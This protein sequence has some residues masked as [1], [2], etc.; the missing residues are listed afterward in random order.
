MAWMILLH[1]IMTERACFQLDQHIGYIVIQN[2]QGSASTSEEKK[3]LWAY[4]GENFEAE[5]PEQDIALC[6]EVGHRF[7]SS[8]Y[9]PETKRHD[10]GFRLF[11][12][13]TI[14]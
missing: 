8:D 11:C 1:G 10:S 3:K 6:S 7:I 9:E 12:L 14:G 13:P 5:L 2:Q 4:L